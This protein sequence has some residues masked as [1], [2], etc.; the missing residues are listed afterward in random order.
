MRLSFSREKW[1]L[2]LVSIPITNEWAHAMS[3]RAEF[4]CRCL[5]SLRRSEL[6]VDDIRWLY[7]GDLR[8]LEQV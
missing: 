1:G 2:V 7:A 8:S 6:I 3:R 5:R 4:A